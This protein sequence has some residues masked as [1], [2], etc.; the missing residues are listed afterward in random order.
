MELLVSLV[1]SNKAEVD[2]VRFFTHTTHTYT[3]ISCDKYYIN[4]PCTGPFERPLPQGRD[5]VRSQGVRETDGSH[6]RISKGQLYS[7]CTYH[8][9][10]SSTV[11]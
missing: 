7:P 4:Y 2:Q 10:D 5:R 3:L 11:L 1:R 8:I 9:K 6:R